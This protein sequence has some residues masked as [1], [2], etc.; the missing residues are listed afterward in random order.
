MHMLVATIV[1]IYIMELIINLLFSKLL[2]FPTIQK[3]YCR[4]FPDLTMGLADA[5]KP[6][7]FSGMYF[8]RWQLKAMLW[9][10]ILKV[11]W[12]TDGK[13]EGDLSEEAQK[14]FQDVNVAIRGCILSVL[15]DRLCDVYMHI[16]DGKE[17][18]DALDA[19]F[20]ATDAGSELYTMESLN[21][22]KMVDN[23]S[24]LEQAHE[25]Q[26]S[27]RE[28]SSFSSVNCPTSTWLG[29]LLQ[30]YLLH[31]GASPRL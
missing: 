19:K 9:L 12:M 20:G 29:A 22:D 7:K 10:Q 28:S 24:V 4:Q 21:D 15:S 13:P 14:N 11:F 6:D 31:G 1:M 25:I 18:W 5:L 2:N 17:P 30:S 26:R 23:R 27:L 8:K 3:P 16:E